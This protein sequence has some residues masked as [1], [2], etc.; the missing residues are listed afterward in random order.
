[1]IRISIKTT[2]Y[3]LRRSDLKAIRINP[4]CVYHHSSDGLSGKAVRPM[5]WLVC[6]VVRHLSRTDVRQEAPAE[7]TPV[8]SYKDCRYWCTNPPHWLTACKTDGQEAR[9]IEI[10]GVVIHPVHHRSQCGTRL[11]VAHPFG[12]LLI[13]TISA[14]GCIVAKR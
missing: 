2:S 12:Q 1:M 9:L 5:P 14:K 8:M 6:K 4:K 11:S 7:G 10:L 13:P 3:H